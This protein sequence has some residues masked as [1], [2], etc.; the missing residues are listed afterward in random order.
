MKAILI[1]P[2]RHEVKGIEV[3]P[4]LHN[5]ISSALGGGKILIVSKMLDWG[6]VLYYNGHAKPPSF[7]FEGIPSIIHGKAIVFGRERGKWPVPI[8]LIAKDIECLVRFSS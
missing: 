3:D 6:L 7:W 2:T 1:D 5:T 4:L 8:T